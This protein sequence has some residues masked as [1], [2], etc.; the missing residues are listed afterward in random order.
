[1]SKIQDEIIKTFKKGS[2]LTKLIYIN[3]GAFIVL[4]FV[5][6]FFDKLQ[7]YFA[8]PGTFKELIYQPWSVVTYQ[9]IHGGLWHLLINMLWLFWF[10]R[11]F[12]N[13]FNEKQLLAVYL[14]GGFVGAFFH[15]LINNFLPEANQVPIIGASGA[16]MS[17]VF[18][19]VAFKPDYS[20]NLLFIGQVK[21]K[22]IAIFVLIL[23][24][25][26]LAGNAKNGMSGSDGIAHIAH[27]GGSAFGLWFGYSMRNGKDITRSFNNFL[28]NFFSWFSTDQSDRKR[29]KMKATKGDLFTKPKSDW[30]YNKDKADERKEVDR[31]LDKIS[32]KGYG[33]L[34]KKEKDFLFQQKDKK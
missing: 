21:I 2:M 19:V 1:M 22:Y 18:A 13:Y 20:I 8:V 17:V 10:G 4:Y 5:F 24:I 28:N 15:L 23:D 31:I 33:S 27:M 7:T 12:L 29:T 34:S 16:V 11:L 6:L 9:F 3:V 14:L 26:G 25:M 30:D 32:K